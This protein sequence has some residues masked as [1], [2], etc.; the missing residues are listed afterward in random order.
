MYHH[1][2]LTF[3]FLV[4]RGFLHVAQAGLKLLTSH[5]LLVSAAQSDRITGMSQ[6]AQPIHF[7]KVITSL[8]L[9]PPTTCFI[10]FEPTQLSPTL[11]RL[12]RL[13]SLHRILLSLLFKGSFLLVFKPQIKCYL[14]QKHFTTHSVFFL[15]VSI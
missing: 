15:A 9:Q 5:N 1:A 2:Q 13:G 7:L 4:E 8:L 14:L 11:V 10:S 6:R 3:L 12:H